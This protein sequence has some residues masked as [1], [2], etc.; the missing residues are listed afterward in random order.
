MTHHRGALSPQTIMTSLSLLLSIAA[1]VPCTATTDVFESDF[2]RLFYNDMGWLDGNI[3][4]MSRFDVLTTAFWNQ[5]GP[6]VVKLDSLALLNP[7]MQRLPYINSAGR[8]FP[9]VSDP[10]HVVNR[11]ANGIQNSW[12]ARNELGQ[13]IYF[14]PQIPDMEMLNLSIKCP[15]VNGKT[16]GEYLADFAATQIMSTGHWEGLYLDNL[17]ASASWINAAIPGSIDFNLDGVADH[18]DSVDSW[19]T[20]G[21]AQFLDRLRNQVGQDAILLGNGNGRQ[22]AYLNGR[23]FE[24]YPFREGWNESMQE[25]SGWQSAGV[26]P[27]LLALV[28]RGAPNNYRLMRYGLCSALIA[29]E[30]S[31]HFDA[32]NAPNPV[33]YDEY[34]VNLGKP[35]GEPIELGITEVA[36]ADFEG[37]LPPELS[38]S[39]G[40][41]EGI[42][43]TNQAQVIDGNVSLLGRPAGVQT[44]Q[45]F[46]C[47]DSGDLPLIAGHTYTLTFNYRIV[48]EPP[49][50]GYFY[51]GT[52]S[53]AD[54]NASNRNILILDPPAGTVGEA[55]GDVTLGNYPGYYLYWGLKNGGQIVIDSIRIIEGQGGAFRRDF[56]YGIALVN[57]TS[58]P[59]TIP[60]GGVYYRLDGTVDPITNNG[61]ST[62]QVT[63]AAEDGLVL[64]DTAPT[65]VDEEAAPAAPPLLLAFPNPAR[66]SMTPAVEITGV[67]RGGSVTIVSPLG[68]IVR[69]LTEH[70]PGGSWRWD[71][72]NASA[73]RAAS[74]VYLALVRDAGRKMVGSVQLAVRR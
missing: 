2:P 64:L 46:L 7:A 44:W 58:S 31:Q 47:S 27:N 8:S 20:R 69:T 67:P 25:V 23:Y 1:V 21:M 55:R 61:M 73:Q 33:F 15:R 45:L 71:L 9:L 51:A 54:L 6:T 42:I 56:E 28:T 38:T 59:F 10:N 62:S 41:G 70:D 32:S 12:Y 35:I 30:F 37:G 39:C 19:W 18:P 66:M 13:L 52:R 48:S 26:N 24:D 4:L 3:Q 36:G 65:A 50:D 22:Y 14:D 57:P 49:G 53:N 60:L 63:L 29:A 34:A 11:L 40:S 16:W 5:E 68:R 74:G 17:W 72:R 43:T